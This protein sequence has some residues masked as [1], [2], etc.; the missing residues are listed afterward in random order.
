MLAKLTDLVSG[1]VVGLAGVV[2]GIAAL[3]RGPAGR[4]SPITLFLKLFQGR[5]LEWSSFLTETLVGS[6]GLMS[7]PAST[8]SPALL[9]QT[10]HLGWCRKPW[11]APLFF[12]FSLSPS[13]LYSL[14]PSL[15]SKSIFILSFFPKSLQVARLHTTHRGTGYNVLAEDRRDRCSHATWAQVPIQPDLG[16]FLVCASVSLSEK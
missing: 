14:F 13:A 12:P 2:W 3:C 6:R 8:L 15:P 5:G 11:S 10:S 4:S 16:A 7:L 9:S 1:A